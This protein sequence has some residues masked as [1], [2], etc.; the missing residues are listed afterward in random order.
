MNTQLK[1]SRLLIGAVLVLSGLVSI[2]GF[3]TPLRA[4][5]ISVTTT[6]DENDGS[7]TDGDC[8]LRD[9]LETAVSGDTISIPSGSYVLTQG[10]LEV[11]RTVTL[12]GGTPAPVLDGNSSSRVFQV[13]YNV[14]LN[15]NNLI[16]TNGSST[17][18]GGIS[19]N[20]G[21]L[22]LINSEIRGN[23][24]SNNGGGI[25]LGNGTI[26][27]NSGTIS[28][29]TAVT[30]G[31][32]IYNMDGTLIQS[33]GSIEG[34]SAAAG[35]GV[36]VNLP[37]AVYTLNDG[38]LQQ[39]SSTAPESGGGGV[40]VAQ[41]T[42]TVNGGQIAENNGVRGGGIESANGQI[43]LNGGIIR[44]NE[45]Q[46]GGGVYLS[47]PD[48]FLTQ[49]GGEISQNVSTA[50]DFGGGGV[51]GF[52][53]SMTLTGGRISQ[54]TAVAHG[55]GVNIRFGDLTISGGEIVHN[56]AGG[57]GGGIFADFSSLSIANLQLG[58][59]MAAEGGGLYLSPFASLELSETAV[60]S[61]TATLNGGGLVLK[62]SALLTNT[63]VGR[64]EAQNNGGGLWLASSTTL[65]NVTLS[66]NTA[67]SGGG[68]FNNGAVV[69]LHN[70]L[71]AGNLA[72]TGP[73]CG[74]TVFTSSGYNFIQNESDCLLDGDLT[75]NILGQD[76]LLQPLTLY[77]GTTYIYPLDAASP[78]V[79]A[80]DPLNCPAT[81]QQ[82]RPRPLDGNMNG[83]AVCD[84]GAFEYGIPLRIG[85]VIVTE[86]DSGS[87]M[88]NFAV[89]LDFAVPVTVT[90]AYASS[91]Q[92]ALADLDYEEVF[93]TL[94]FDPGQTTQTIA[95]PILGDLLDEVDETFVVTLTNPTRAYLAKGQAVGT[96]LDN[97]PLP[98]LSINDV[99]VTE[100]D[101]GSQTASF[102]VTL[103]APSSKTVQV[104]Y[105]TANGTAVVGADYTA[106]SGTLTFTPGQTS[107]TIPVTILNDAVAEETE[108]FTISLSAPLNA[109]LSTSQG[110]G[111]I[112]DNDPLPPT[113][114]DYFVY[115]PV[116][117]RP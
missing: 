10:Q 78:A 109:T 87:T 45:A 11:T 59:N 31:G 63:T 42:V 72:G 66:E 16:V 117:I 114:S 100:G 32:G 1:M 26:Q 83:T 112:L 96:I 76:P 7:C 104:S 85:D 40:Y 48:A 3:A 64:N 55:G 106:V 46:Y 54:N 61:N 67:V 82:G 92:S 70:S 89:T 51:L 8:S 80:G 44:A 74:G 49:A 90:V 17:D 73:E 97:D 36:Y 79:D 33:G 53:G 62:G 22:I 50:A 115:L 91:G 21:E 19:V 93:G 94:T 18:G 30:N 68:L 110:I 102:G 56:Q 84:I 95:V 86:G 15:L 12:V 105:A 41:G 6:L 101:S 81:D 13:P 24:A 43:F 75:G 57:Q 108:T 23:N 103:S 99:T 4:A 113:D 69:Y 9:A 29:N 111:T 52:Q 77:S 65:N 60:Y 38:L 39:N 2:T 47:F 98:G 107:K 14:S 25:F 116:V 35:G 88:A 34:N 20:G 5:I 58:D 37:D 27:L 28:Q 71:L